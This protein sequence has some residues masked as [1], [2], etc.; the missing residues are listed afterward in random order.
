MID[1]E[2]K[3]L[4]QAIKIIVDR[5]GKDVLNDVRL[6]NIMSDVVT[7]E[8]S[9]A[10]K[11]TFREIIKLGYGKKILSLVS[12]KGDIRMKIRVYAKSI[13]DTKGYNE[14][15][16][17]Y[18]L[19]SISYSVGL[20]KEPYLKNKD[21]SSSS[22]VDRVPQKLHKETPEQN[23]ERSHFYKIIVGL[24]SFF[25]FVGCVY[26][27]QYYNSS[28]DREQYEKRV[29]SGNN[30]LSKGDYDN[31]IESYKEAYNGYNALNS[32][33]YKEAALMRM[34][35][36]VD[37]LCNEGNDNNK[38]LLQA[39]KL[40]QSEM[41]LNLDK[42]DLSRLQS[43]KDNIEKLINTRVSNGRNSLISIVSAN[44]GKL[45]AD[46]KALLI[47]LLELSPNDYWLNFIKKKSYE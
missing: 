31:A 38:S 14:V 17:Q 45:D 10:V 28:A 41:Q 8:D 5:Y 43:K 44:N 20:C 22:V 47:D 40:L 36:L 16:V 12:A 27:Y 30:F 18:V 3:T 13:A 19:Y 6:V 25:I 15:I 21:V 29:T 1:K 4:P 46:G 11:N 33:S 2:P 37:K 9:L 34:D 42:E 26:L 39:Y 32:G 35:D 7:L 23:V 24:I